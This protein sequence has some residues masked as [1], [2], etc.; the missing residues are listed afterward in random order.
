[1]SWQFATAGRILYGRG[2]AARVA[3]ACA[4]LGIRHP[5][6]VTDRALAE[7]GTA[8]RIEQTLHSVC[9]QVTVF[10]E[11]VA[12]PPVECAERAASTGRGAAVDGIVALGGGSNLDVGKLV[13]AMLRHGGK[14]TDYF[15]FDRIPGPVL[16]L[17]A[18]PTTAGTGSEVSHS[19][20][21]TDVAAGV[22][23]SCLSPFLRPALA[24]VDPALTD[25]CPPRVTAHSG[26][27]AL[28]HAIEAFTAR[29]SE[30]MPESNPLERVYDGANPFTRV[31]AAEAIRLVGRSLQ[32]AV[33]N[34]SDFAARDDMALA[35]MLAGMAFSNSGVAV[36]HALEYPIGALT[37]C[38]HGEGNGLLLPHVMRFNLPE[39]VG[40]MAEI[41][42][43][44]SGQPATLD[45]R[46]PASLASITASPAEDA[47]GAELNAAAD[48]DELLAQAE[49]AIEQIVLLQR[50]IGIRQR[51]RDLGLAEDALPGVAAKSIRI[52]RLMDTNP[53][54]PGEADLLAIL[55]AAY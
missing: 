20:V 45:G 8:G 17:I 11:C 44:L 19:G 22:K 25:T 21:L 29:A 50:A 26:I 51:L 31:L 6:L 34:G 47:G 30:R 48:A 7:L 36:V 3:A 28:V 16:P 52:Q 5:L 42:R 37:H 54:T 24:I 12:E 10:A 33:E 39:R 14:P 15:G 43:L 40:E 41:G 53:R 32:R 27:D 38:S 23:V 1:V 55:E 46:Q 2:E 4:R 18:L 9:Q 13:A 49:F 35:A